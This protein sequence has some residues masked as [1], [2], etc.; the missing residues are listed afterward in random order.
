MV[1]KLL[2]DFSDQNI[3]IMYT[4]DFEYPNPET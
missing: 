2:F 3:G 4:F 1:R